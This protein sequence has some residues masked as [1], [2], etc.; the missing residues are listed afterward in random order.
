MRPNVLILFTDDQRFNT[1]NALGNADIITPNMDRLVGEGV[2]MT[3]AHIMGG[4]HVAICLPSR[5][6]L[7][8]GRSMYDLD[9]VGYLIPDHHKMMPEHFRSHGYA[10]FGTGKWHNS[11]ESYARCFSDGGQ[12]FFGGM[13]DHWNVP[14]CD[15]RADGVYPDPAPHTYQRYGGDRAELSYLR[16][17]RFGRSHSTTLFCDEAIDFLT[18]R[19][20]GDAPF[21]AYVSFLAPHD[22]RE[23]PSEVL[24]L[25]AGRDIAIPANVMGEHPFDNGDLRNRDELLAGFPRDE[26]EIRRHLV[27]YYAMITHADFEIGRVLDALEATGAYDDTIVVLTGDNGLAVGSHG[28]MGKQN[29]YDHSVRVPLVISGPGLATDRSCDALCYLHDLFPTLCDNVGLDIPDS[30]KTRSFASCLRDPSL[31]HR[32]YLLLGYIAY[33]RGITDGTYKLIEYVVDGSHREHLFNLVADPDELN[34]LSNDPDHATTRSRMKSLLEH[35]RTDFEDT[36]A[37]GK[38]FW[39]VA[40]PEGERR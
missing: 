24:Q 3:Q 31:R 21:F 5:A 14:V 23:M 29:L 19:W 25:Y 17:D 30:V 22:P 32:D 13:T 2:A 10:T 27:E 16:W 9:D 33:Q 38:A 4:T 35:W 6:M 34:D 18:N 20:S 39:S 12:I 15:F 37:H 1:I 7:L 40:R 36:G 28:L 26:A 8:T 11:C